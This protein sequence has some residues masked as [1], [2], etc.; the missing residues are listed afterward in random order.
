MGKILLIIGDHDLNYLL[1]DILKMYSFSV[2]SCFDGESA[3]EKF[4]EGKY[5]IVIV[6]Y[7]LP[8]MNGIG[9]IMKLK[10]KDPNVKTFLLA[11][12]TEHPIE[13]LAFQTGA[14]EFIKKPFDLM[15]LVT[16]IEKYMIFLLVF[17]YI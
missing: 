5:D 12:H 13:N 17:M 1:K 2:E 8:E 3:L 9:C 15:E 11:D 6:D 14:N 7:A 10:E 16:L 4:R